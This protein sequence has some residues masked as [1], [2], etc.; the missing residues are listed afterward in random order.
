MI[1]TPRRY[2]H[3]IIQAELLVEFFRDGIVIECMKGLSNQAV[4][5]GAGFDTFSGCFYITLEHPDW[6]L[7]PEG[8]P[9]PFMEPPSFQVLRRKA[10]VGCKE[11]DV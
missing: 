2:R 9:I 1:E 5:K 6:D 8:K 10:E 11:G 7:V 4:F 3:L